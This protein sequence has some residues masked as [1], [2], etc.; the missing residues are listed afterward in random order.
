MAIRKFGDLPGGYAIQPGSE[1]IYHD[2]GLIEGTLVVE[3]DRDNDGVITDLV[4]GPHPRDEDV[5]LYALRLRYDR[6]D[7]VIAT[8]DCLGTEGRAD[9][10]RIVVPVPSKEMIPIEAHPKFFT[11]EM[12][13]AEADLVMLGD[14]N[15]AEGANGARFTVSTNKK[16]TGFLGF[17]GPDAP[18]DLRPLRFFERNTP[19]L[20]AT[21]YSWDDPTF[22]F[23]SVIVD[24]PAG[25]PNFEGIENW[26]RSSPPASRVGGINSLT[27]WKMTQEYVGSETGWSEAVYDT[28]EE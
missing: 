6:L 14:G 21:W 5:F 15:Y 11:D 10:D 16:I 13:G 20:R 1:L 17:S 23:N 18:D 27:V 19:I 9:T 3:T 4:G 8:F 25:A 7:K 26:L 24:H 22:A 12:A 28:E 2:D